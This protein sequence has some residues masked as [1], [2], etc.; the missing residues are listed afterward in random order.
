[1][2]GGNATSN[3]EII[4]I[5][6]SVINQLLAG[7]VRKNYIHT[8]STWTIGGAPPNNNNQVG[9]NVMANST[10]E[11]FFQPSNCFDCH[12]G[13]MLGSPNGGGLSHV[14]GPLKPLF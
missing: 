5:N 6:N 1:M 3:T 8:G 12:Q 9:T 11:S 7:D 14:Y 2:P 13:N 4:S 10:M